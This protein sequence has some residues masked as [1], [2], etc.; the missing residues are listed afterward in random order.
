MDRSIYCIKKPQTEKSWCKKE[1]GWWMYKSI[2]DALAAKLNSE[3]CICSECAVA[4]D[5]VLNN[6]V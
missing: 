2:Q 4:I 1:G 6:L 3:V 5:K